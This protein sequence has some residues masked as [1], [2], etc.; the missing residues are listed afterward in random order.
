MRVGRYVY[1]F[2]TYAPHVGRQVGADTHALYGKSRA[3]WSYR[4]LRY[5]TP[6][7][8]TKFTICVYVYEGFAVN[9]NIYILGVRVKM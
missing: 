6:F 9:N 8:V 1:T 4:I 3:S 5:I 2:T 7:V